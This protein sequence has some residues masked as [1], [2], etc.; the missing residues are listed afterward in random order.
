MTERPTQ[1]ELEVLDELET[2]GRPLGHEELANRLD[3]QWN[4]LRR[5]IQAL[6]RKGKVIITIDRR[7]KR[8]D[9][10]E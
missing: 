10:D 8:T 4:E 2:T 7:Y 9:T 5:R 6:R 3:I 1:R